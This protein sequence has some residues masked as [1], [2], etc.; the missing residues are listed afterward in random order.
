[1]TKAEYII[2]SYVVR[3]AIEIWQFINKIKQETVKSL[4]LYGN[5][6]KSI[7]LTKNIES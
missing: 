4:T 2:L 1:M 7:I 3:K 6:E 5:N